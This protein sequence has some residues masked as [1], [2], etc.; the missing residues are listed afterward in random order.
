MSKIRKIRIDEQKSPQKIERF[1][2]GLL[3]ADSVYIA[4]RL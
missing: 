2:R 4:C 3:F 1:L